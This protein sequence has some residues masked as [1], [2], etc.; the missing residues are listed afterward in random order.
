MMLITA[1]LLSCQT[2]K[3][4]EE[5]PSNEEAKEKLENLS[6]HEIEEDLP[7]TD[8]AKV[9]SN[10]NKITKVEK[11]SLSPP[12]MKF[13]TMVYDY[14]TI[15]SGEVINYNFKFVNIG[16][17]PLE[18]NNVIGSCG[19]TA[20][21]FNFLPFPKGDSGVIKARFNSKGKIGKQENTLTIKSNHAGGDQLLII[22][23][24]VKDPPKEE[25][26]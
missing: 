4:V 2:D 11:P 17:R 15:E 1:L 10:E 9:D 6:E 12:E 26:N 21:S 5:Q 16:D 22:K 19:C 23:G 14:G 13:D 25:D 20:A 18:I 7:Q 3:P 24:M 8:T